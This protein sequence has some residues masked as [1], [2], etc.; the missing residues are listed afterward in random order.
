MDCRGNFQLVW[1][2]GIF[3][4]LS[5]SNERRCWVFTMSNIADGQAFDIPATI[6]DPAILDEIRENL[7]RAGIGLGAS[8]R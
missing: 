7:D 4:R 2:N 3:F 6:D 1:I 8:R 5:G